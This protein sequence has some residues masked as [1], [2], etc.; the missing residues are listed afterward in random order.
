[1]FSAPERPFPASPELTKRTHFGQAISVKSGTYA[2]QKEPVPS[3]VRTRTNR[4]RRPLRLDPSPA[5]SYSLTRK[6]MFTFLPRLLLLA[7]LFAAAAL[8]ETGRDAWLRYA[9]LDE[10]SASH[11]RTEVTAAVASF[12]D[13][14]VLAAA[15]D[16]LQRGVR[17]MLGRTLRVESALPRENAIVIG[18]VESLPV[19][20][21]LRHRC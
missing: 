9:P 10:L 5:L 4:P 13:S 16:E 14:P 21:G 6:Q 7:G 8:A 18:T 17:G 11:A 12:G 20:A 1:M 3:P 19:L 15:R 2:M